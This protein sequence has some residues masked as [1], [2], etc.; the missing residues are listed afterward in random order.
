MTTT[1]TALIDLRQQIDGIDD[2]LHDLVI[3]RAGLVD[4]IR[5][6]KDRHGVPVLQPGR[7]VQ[8]LRRLA[9]RHHGAFPFGAVARIWREMI[10]ALTHMQQPL[11]VA[12]YAPDGVQG[13]WDLARDHFGSIVPMT[14]HGS[15]NQ[16]IRAVTDRSALV[17][18]L[19]MP[20][21]HEK[22]PWWRQLL[23]GDTSAP[24]V[25]ARLPATERGNARGAGDVLAIACNLNDFAGVDRSLVAME[26]SGQV[27]RTKLMSCLT[28]AG[29]ACGLLAILT[30]DGLCL[31]LAEIQ[32]PLAVDDERFIELANQLGKP[33]DGLYRLGGYADPVV[34]A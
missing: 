25:F 7:E 5:Q 22:D 4:Q 6:R 14:A 26:I 34:P 32:G 28:S 15:I 31:A 3:A 33:I 16:V 19:P 24:R 11:A 9:A 1:D 17:G 21:E 12:V 13:P 30:R 2:Q 20:L 8:V 27:S 23:T 10:S 18:V 29:F